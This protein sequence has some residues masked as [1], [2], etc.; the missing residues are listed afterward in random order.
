MSVAAIRGEDTRYVTLMSGLPYHGP[1]FAAKRTPLSRIQLERRLRLLHEDDRTLLARI[2]GLLK[3]DRIDTGLDD[4]A[5]IREADALLA[6]LRE[7]TLHAAVRERI[8]LRTLVAALRRRHLGQGSPSDPA[9]LG[10]GRWIRAIRRNWRLPAFGLAHA[11]PWLPE[12]E[13]LLDASDPLGL[14]KLLLHEAWTRLGR[15]SQGHAFDFPAVV[16][17]V[18]RWDIIDRWVRYDGEAAARRYDA[19]LRGSLGAH[20]NLFAENRANA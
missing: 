4:A 12:A 14:E 2:E 9:T 16:L 15:L 17:Y 1:L 18:L 6:S 11:F 8:E 10:H 20:A 5:L 13:R 7:P 3:W 19:L